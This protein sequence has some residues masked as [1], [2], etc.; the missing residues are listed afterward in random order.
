MSMTIFP[1]YEEA[2]KRVQ[3]KGIKS[4][5][6]Y[7]VSYKEL[8]LPSAPSDHYKNAGWIDWYE[9][10]GTKPHSLPTYEEAKRIVQEKGVGQISEYLSCYK[11]LGLPS[12]PHNTYKGKGWINWFE[13]LGKK[14]GSYPKYDEAQRIL[15]EKGINSIPKYKAS[16]KAL[17]LPSA[18]ERHYNGHG[19]T[20]WHDFFA[21][22]RKEFPPYEEAKRIVLEKGIKNIGEYKASYKEVGLPSAPEKHYK[23]SG[24][25][26]WSNF[27]N[28]DQ[29][30]SLKERKYR[31]LTKL[32]NYPTLLEENAPLQVIYILASELDKNLAK[33]MEELLGKTSFEERLNWVKEQL[34]NLK[35][36]TI[37][38]H[39]T[40][41]DTPSDELSAMESILEE[42]H[43]TD[44]VNFT[45]ENYLHSAVN[46]ELISEYDG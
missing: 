13:F 27:F 38:I 42:F 41:A 11:G 33:E 4:M 8:G 5:S 29:K 37:S 26:C 15:K 3:D 9:F 14:G 45:L 44:K 18:P 35:E 40:I 23:K 1:T 28:K 31:I 30:I 10:L 2:L 22:E 16:Y 20:G 24:W 21:K 19:W 25:T 17:G 6:E 36:E 34:K 39:K 43:V 32:S 46:R 7:K 12:E